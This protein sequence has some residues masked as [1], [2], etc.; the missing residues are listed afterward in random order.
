[1][2]TTSLI[3]RI[4]GSSVQLQALGFIAFELWKN[5]RR[6]V[7]DNLTDRERREFLDLIRTSRGRRANL[8]DRQQHHFAELTR[9]A[10]TGEGDASWG[11]VVKSLPTLVPTRALTQGVGRFRGKG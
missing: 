3:T 8:N 1:M 7:E 5:A 9:K 2:A 6:R 11:D 10:A 4:R